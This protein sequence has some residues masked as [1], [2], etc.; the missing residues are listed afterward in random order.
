MKHNFSLEC[1]HIVLMP[2]DEESSEEYRKL[3]NREDNQKFFF[4]S[5][6]IEKEQQIRWFY[7]Y[8][9]RENEYM[10]A[11]FLKEKMKFVGGIGIY[12]IDI[13]KK[14]AEIGRIIIDRRLASGKGYG[15]ETIRGIVDI[16]Q[17]QLKLKEMYAFIY[18]TNIASIK[19][20]LRA[21][22]IRDTENDCNEIIR[23][24]LKI[25]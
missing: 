20:F 13:I 8:L 14:T 5:A 2:M 6:V 19:S 16:F 11:V 23:V 15:T 1:D 21:G 3:R 25:N 22:F 24:S 17:N 10:F 4:H 7:N 18:T 9:K 12:D